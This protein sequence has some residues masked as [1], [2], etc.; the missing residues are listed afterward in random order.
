[1]AKNEN[2]RLDGNI[3]PYSKLQPVVKNKNYY[4]DPVGGHMTR[5]LNVQNRLRNLRTYGNIYGFVSGIDGSNPMLQP[6]Q[7]G[8]R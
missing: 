2:V 6:K 7:F 5:H 4:N 3:K 1:M 8:K